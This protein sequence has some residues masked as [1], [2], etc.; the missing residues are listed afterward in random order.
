MEDETVDVVDELGDVDAAEDDGDILAR[1]VT[2]TG[3]GTSIKDGTSNTWRP[4]GTRRAIHRLRA[5]VRLA[6]EPEIDMSSRPGQAVARS[7]EKPAK[8]RSATACTRS[9]G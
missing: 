1:T 4:V 3:N 6:G 5:V 8:A 7:G 9:S 2:P